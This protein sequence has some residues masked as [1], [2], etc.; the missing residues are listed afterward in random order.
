MTSV[1]RD[2][3]AAGDQRGPL[4]TESF[5]LI[6]ADVQWKEKLRDGTT[7]LIRAIGDE[8]AEFERSFIERLSPQSRRF[9]FLGEIKSP[10]SRLL[11]QLTH[12]DQVNDVAF[13]ALIADGAIERE[14]GVSRY[15]KLADGVTCECAIAVS[16]EWHNQ[17]LA[18]LL[19]NHLI[20]FAREHG[21]SRMYSVDSPDNQA[22]RDLAEHLGFVRTRD[23]ND[24]R[25]VMH[26]LDLNAPTV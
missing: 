10:D 11:R 17:G 23:P 5:N 21:I 14:I 4:P 2:V 3:S 12:V 26:T 8:D 18:T 22:M 24:A 16:D 6:R 13:V 1:D 15:S 19:L 25:Q 7:V 20:Q 9:R